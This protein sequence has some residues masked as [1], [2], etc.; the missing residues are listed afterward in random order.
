VGDCR[1][2]VRLLQA[3]LDLGQETKLFDRFVQGDIIRKLLDG[4]GT[5]PPTLASVVGFDGIRP[6]RCRKALKSLAA[7]PA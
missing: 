4:L 6:S 1:S 2:F 3:A 7:A 5:N